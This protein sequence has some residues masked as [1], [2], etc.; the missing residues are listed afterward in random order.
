MKGVDSNGSPVCVADKDTNSTYGAS[1]GLTLSGGYFSVK[2]GGVNASRLALSSTTTVSEKY[3]LTCY[4]NTSSC[5]KTISGTTSSSM[6]FL[7][8][9]EFNNDGGSCRTYYTGGKWV[10]QLIDPN[11]GNYAK[12]SAR[13]IK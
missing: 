8:H 7:V 6:C 2:S 4:S 11:G 13:C 5:K 1:T 12:C 3:G 9:S 10:V